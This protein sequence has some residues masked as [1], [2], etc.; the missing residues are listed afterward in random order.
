MKNSAPCN[1]RYIAPIV[2]YWLGNPALLEKFV[3]E[4]ELFSQGNSLEGF[5]QTSY[6]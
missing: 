5:M 6:F 1:V 2:L 4:R 3:W